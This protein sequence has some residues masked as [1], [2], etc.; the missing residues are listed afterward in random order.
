MLAGSVGSQGP[1]A[2]GA[3]HVCRA[4]CVDNTLVLVIVTASCNAH[5]L[6]ASFSLHQQ[7]TCNN[8]VGRHNWLQLRAGKWSSTFL[9][10]IQQ[11]R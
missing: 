8:V 11:R 2:T 4:M 9:C 1:A 10:K 5:P 7:L 3:W 6:P